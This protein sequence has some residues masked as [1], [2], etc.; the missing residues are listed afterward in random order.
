MRRPSEFANCSL[1]EAVDVILEKEDET[2]NAK[3]PLAACLMS[4]EELNGEN[5][6][7]WVLALEGRG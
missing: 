6:A 5:L 7:E 4:L 3:D 1:I 2:L